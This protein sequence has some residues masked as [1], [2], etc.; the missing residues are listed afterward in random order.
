MAAWGQWFGTL[1]SAIVDAG[2]PLRPLRIAWAA[3]GAD[4]AAKSGLSGY[5]VLTADSLAAA[6]ELAQGLPGDRKRRGGGCLRDNPGDV[7]GIRTRAAPNKDAQ[8]P[9]RDGRHQHSG[10]RPDRLPRRMR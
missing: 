6:T 2:N 5:S 4:G 8:H 9:R 10:G 3:G 1:G 7:A